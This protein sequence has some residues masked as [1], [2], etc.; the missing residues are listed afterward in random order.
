[1]EREKR[2][3]N[4]YSKFFSIS[5]SGFLFRV[6]NITLAVAVGFTLVSAFFLLFVGMV[7]GVKSMSSFIELGEV[8]QVLSG[9]I[10]TMDIFLASLVMMLLALGIYDLFVVSDDAGD[11]NKACRG[12]DGF[13]TL[14]DLKSSLAKLIVVILT[15]T[16]LELVL[17]NLDYL[18]G[19]EI[20]I[21]PLGALL[22]A[23]SLWLTLKK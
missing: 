10:K 22:I 13:S 6:R 11:E 3:K 12:W 18:T 20:L 21:A 2:S 4:S 17:S 5:L 14:D 19:F 9:L 23:S 1:M 15:V 8:A 7:N 16:F